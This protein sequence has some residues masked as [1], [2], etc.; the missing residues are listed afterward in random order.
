MYLY[1]I[2]ALKPLGVAFLTEGEFDCMAL[3]ALGLVAVSSAQ[4]R[5]DSD[6]GSP[7]AATDAGAL[8]RH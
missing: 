3:A 1:N 2:D 4:R 6:A 8:R 7:C 5:Q